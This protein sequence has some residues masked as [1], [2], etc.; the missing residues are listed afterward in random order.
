MLYGNEV[1]FLILIIG[2]ADWQAHRFDKEQKPIKHWFWAL[3][4]GAAIAAFWYLSHKQYYFAG[5]LILEHV[6]FF[7]TILNYFRKPR[8]AFFYLHSDP[9]TGS[10]FDKLLANPI[11][12]WPVIWALSLAGFI[13]LQFFI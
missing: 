12:L 3:V 2:I 8:K 13:T 1:I 4:F 9:K 7:P 10:W 5:A 6:V 11:W